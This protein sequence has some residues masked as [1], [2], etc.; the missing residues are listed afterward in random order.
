MYNMYRSNVF[1]SRDICIVHYSIYLSI[2]LYIYLSL[3]LS[4][5]IYS[6]YMRFMYQ[7]SILYAPHDGV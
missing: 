1:V 4:I 3:D 6:Y 7:N 5:Y 2:C